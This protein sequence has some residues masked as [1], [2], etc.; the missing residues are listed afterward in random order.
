M[1]VYVI[2]HK[3]PDTDSVTAAIAYAALMKAKGED[4]VPAVSGKLNPE[5]EMVLKQFGFATPELLTDATGK[6]IALVDHSDLT[7][8]PDNLNAGEV[9]AVVDHHKIGD[10]TTNQPIFFFN[11][12]VGCTGTVLKILYD[13]EGV[14]VEPKVAGLMLAAILSDTV[15]FK[16]PTTTDADKKAVKELAAIAGVTDTE[17]LFME[18]LKAKSAVAGVPAMDLLHR[19]YKDFDMNGKKVGVGQL[20][21]ATLDQVADMRDALYNAMKEQKGTERHSVLLMLTDVVKEG[22]DLMVISDDPALIEGAFGDKLDGVSMWID[23]M[24][25]RKK[26]TVPNLQ[27]A[28]GC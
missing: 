21:L 28:F 20:E 4:Y 7:Q 24:M 10:V 2:G 6:K 13:M 14:K 15:N 17:G 9:V 16:S 11:M 26:Q 25:S 5:S 22:T 18:M 23:G 1:S 12:P 3:S 8:A 19:D 27:K